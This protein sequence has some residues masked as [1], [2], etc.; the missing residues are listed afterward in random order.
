M[1]NFV[2]LKI[3]SASMCFNVCQSVT[4]CTSSAYENKDESS[5]AIEVLVSKFAFCLF[6]VLSIRTKARSNRTCASFVPRAGSRF[7]AFAATLR[8]WL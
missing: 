7:A 4:F 1:Q 3:A 2:A 8:A 5:A 6:L